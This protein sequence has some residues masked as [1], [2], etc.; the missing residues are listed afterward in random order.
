MISKSFAKSSFVFTIG[1]ALPML[2]S[3]LMLPFYTNYLSDVQYTQVL[4]YISVSLLFQILFSFSVDSYFGVQYTQLSENESAQKKFTGTVSILL[5]SI[6]GVIILLSAIFGNILFSKLYATSIE[7][8]FWPYGFYSILTAFFN[9]YFKAASI[10]LIYQKKS[11]LFLATNLINF[12]ATIGIT[13]GGLQ[14]FPNT[15]IGPIYGRLVSGLIIFILAQVIFYANSIYKLNSS[16]LPELIRFCFPYFIYVLCGWFLSQADRY[17]LQNNINLSYLN[18]YDLLM[19]CFFGIEFLQNS[20]SAVIYPKLFE[21]WAKNKSNKTTP[22]SNRYFNV[23]TVL[24]IFWLI[25]FCIFIPII[26]PLIIKKEGFFQAL[27]YIGIIA[28]GYATRS[29][30]NFYLSTI[31]YSKKINVL[32]KIFVVN[33]IIQLP[34]TYYFILF[35]GLTGAIYAALI[36]KILQ[37]VLSVIFTK[38][39]FN[40]DFNFVKIFLIPATFFAIN[41]VQFQF[42]KTYSLSFYV[43]ELCIF[44]IFVYFIF[45]TEIKTTLANFGIIRKNIH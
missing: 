1:G 8:K 15:I 11:K 36:V 45:K 24:N 23:F 13:V 6:G 16:F 31:L 21:I 32:L 39:V 18:S 37:C 38:N 42:S 41:L 10:L 12:I 34:L 35:F 5:L 29:I 40:Y 43:T 30:I 2:A 26:Y 14:I 27:P 19:K 20:L 9:S 22:E 3:I 33:T 4:F 44:C 17:V 28:A 25:L 7:M